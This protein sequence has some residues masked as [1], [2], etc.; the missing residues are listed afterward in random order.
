MSTDYSLREGAMERFIKV[1]KP[2]NFLGKAVSLAKKQRSSKKRF[3]TLL[4][5]EDCA[6]DA[7]HM[8]TVFYDGK[9]GGETTSGAY[10]YRVTC[11]LRL[12]YGRLIRR[13]QG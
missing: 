3:A 9:V 13:L 2:Q 5:D 1:H 6:A 10:G 12:R 8:S 7:P 11:L 4:V